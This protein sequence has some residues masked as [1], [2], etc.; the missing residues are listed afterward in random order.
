[1][2]TFKFDFDQPG[3]QTA[4][5]ACSDTVVPLSLLARP[6]L[7][8]PGTPVRCKR[9]VS[10]STTDGFTFSTSMEPWA[11]SYWG[12]TSSSDAYPN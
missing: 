1:M 5:C 2:W 10:L 12:V 6:P 8:R 4:P 9:S 7:P 3:D 11:R